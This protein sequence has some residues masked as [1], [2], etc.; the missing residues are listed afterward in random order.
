M[1]ASTT[2]VSPPIPTTAERS[3]WA[4]WSA[5]HRA[6]LCFVIEGERV[7]LIRKKRGLGAG[8]I[9]GPGGK[10]HRGETAIQCAARETEEELRI[11]PLGLETGGRLLFQFTDGYSIDVTVFRARGYE[12]TPTETDEAT[13]LWSTFDEVPYAEMWKDDELWLPPFLEGRTFQGRFIFDGDEMV[14]H[15]LEVDAPLESIH[16]HDSHLIPP[17]PSESTPGEKTR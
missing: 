9:N 13:P 17:I 8:K 5:V 14:D 1:T 16:S 6:T 4:G 7:L 2:T 10:L 11:R 12:G 3:E 15:H